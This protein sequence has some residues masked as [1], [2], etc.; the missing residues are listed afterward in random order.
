MSAVDL[1]VEL[2]SLQVGPAAGEGPLGAG[3]AWSRF[4][5]RVQTSSI[6]ATARQLQQRS[7][8][9]RLP[10]NAWAALRCAW[11]SPANQLTFPLKAR[12]ALRGAVGPP[13]SA[14]ATL[15]CGPCAGALL[16]VCCGPSP[17]PSPRRPP[18]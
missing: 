2:A 9:A 5:T 7:S 3:L 1:L 12:A 6:V 17:V 10:L 18:S 11:S 16:T 14:F 13:Q 8:L 4:C 15:R